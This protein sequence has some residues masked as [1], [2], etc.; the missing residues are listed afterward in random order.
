MFSLSRLPSLP[1]PPSGM[2]HRPPKQRSVCRYY[3]PE[4]NSCYYGDACQFQH[5]PPAADHHHHPQMGAYGT[6][7]QQP[8]MAPIMPS[9]PADPA[10]MRSHSSGVPGAMAPVVRLSGIRGLGRGKLT[11]FILKS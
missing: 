6:V 5:A 2:N 9:R 10:A 7:Q 11:C 8:I 4:N 1:G 3:S